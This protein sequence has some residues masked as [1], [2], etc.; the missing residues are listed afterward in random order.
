MDAA[1]KEGAGHV[2]KPQPR[3]AGD[4]DEKYRRSYQR[5]DTLACATEWEEL[6]KDL[7]GI[8][9][10]GLPE[11]KQRPVSFP[12]GVSPSSPHTSR[13]LSSFGGLFL[14]RGSSERCLPLHS[15]PSRLKTLYPQEFYPNLLQ[16]FVILYFI[17]LKSSCV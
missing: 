7:A 5:A 4:G 3:V 17:L 11:T 12:V 13:R 2:E 1:S 15:K 9:L 14:A 6:V 10:T 8:H 16:N